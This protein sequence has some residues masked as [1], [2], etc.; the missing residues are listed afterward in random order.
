M[1]QPAGFLL[2]YPQSEPERRN[3]P[4]R[5]RSVKKILPSLLGL[6]VLHVSLSAQEADDSNASLFHRVRDPMLDITE[7]FETTLPGTLKR[8]NMVLD[9]SPKFGDLRNREYIRY[10]LELRY[11]LSD[12][13][14]LFGGVTP[15]SPSPFNSG[16]DHRWGIGEVRVGIRE[17]T[18]DGI[19]F[20]D[21]ATYGL[22]VRVPLGNPP[23]R[24]IDGYTHVRPFLTASRRLPWPHTKFF[25]TFSYDRAV[26]TPSR[27]KPWS[28]EF[29]HQ[30]IAQVAPGILYKPSQYGY[31]VQ[32]DFRHLDE[33][34]G[35]RLSHEVRVGMLW[36]VPRSRSAWLRLPGKWQVEIALKSLKEE[37]RSIDLGI[38]T[39]IRVRTTL[40]E[41][42]QSDLSKPFRR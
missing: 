32:Y 21:R 9:F 1:R 19:A 7:F 10:P 11:G 23:I 30:H 13:T 24:L 8:Y 33:D 14:E 27:E 28:N 31:F 12:T 2:V 26:N 35:V 6:L 17:D 36:D 41:V 4:Q 34:I 20:Y 5:S 16:R 22:E 37:G 39:R 15:Y 18:E 29:I 40:H 38:A 25:T 3:S 42:M